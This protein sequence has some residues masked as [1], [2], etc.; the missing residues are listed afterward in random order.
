MR[1][2]KLTA[3]I[4]LI[5]LFT[6]VVNYIF[7]SVLNAIVAFNYQDSIINILFLPIIG[8]LV[9]HIYQ[10]YGG[11]S[12]NGFK[13]VFNSMDHKDKEIPKQHGILL[14]TT[15][16]LS[17]L[18][19]ASV[20]REGVA[21][22]VGA[23]IAEHT[24]NIFKLDL[25]SDEEK[26]LLASGIAAGFAALFGTPLAGIF[27]G[28]ELSQNKW[29]NVRYWLFSIPAAF[30]G[31]GVTSIL[32]LSHFHYHVNL[33][34]YNLD[35]TGIFT[36][37]LIGIVF[38]LCGSLFA[39]TLRK[40]KEYAAKIAPNP[41][42]RVLYG[43]IILSVLLIV[44]LHGRYTS[45]G[46]NIITE[47]F[48]SPDLIHNYDF[49]LKL[50]LTCFA[51]SIG[52]QGGEVTPIFSIGA[53]LGVAIASIFSLPLALMGALGY[54][55]V[56]GAATNTYLASSL[57]CIEIFGPEIIIPLFITMGSTFYFRTP[58]SIYP[59]ALYKRKPVRIKQ[60]G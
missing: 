48:N 1:K 6:G 57:I 17:H 27:F 49:I 26:D 19:G 11:E 52:L 45:L 21:V 36:L 42:K 32:G 44:L 59:P 53:S 33:D 34:N 60:K 46:T 8:L 14:I 40:G 28:F 58:D 13:Q 31:M 51:L 25:S 55:C 7:G 18:V 38:A 2:V 37:V 16:W 54:A 22:Q 47:S 29:S 23:S 3:L 56:F 50:F 30:I 5:G 43:G 15:T 4:G 41:Y 12:K 39:I 20:G 10:K 35:L 24:K 9:V